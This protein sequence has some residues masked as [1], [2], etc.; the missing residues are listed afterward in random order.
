MRALSIALLLST[1][2]SAAPLRFTVVTSSGPIATL[3]VTQNGNQLDDV[4]RADDNG[5]GSK[6]D[7]HIQLGP[8]GLPVSW[9]VAGKGWYGA[10]V[11][12]HF[13]VEG[14]KAR[15]TSL[16]GSGEADAKDALY[17]AND[18]T[19]YATQIYLQVLLA[20]K[21]HR[22]AVVPGG[23]L[24]AERLHDVTI[25]SGKTKEVV[26]AWTLWGFGV[27]PSFVLVRKDR[28][29]AS[30]SPGWVFVED[31]HKGEFDALSKLAADLS[32]EVLRALTA[33]VTHRVDGP[34]WLTGVRV[35]DSATGKV[36]APT[37][38]GVFR[39]SIVYV[40]PN[41]PPPD[42]TLVDGAGGTLLPGLFDS[43]D[44]YGD[45]AGP[46]HLACGVTFGRDPG[47]D[48]D[49]I[50]RL[51]Q[52][53]HSGEFLGPR[54]KKSGFLE[55]KS[56]FSAHT[57]FIVDSVEEAKTK[58]RWYA[59]HGFWGIKIYNSMNP[60]LVKPIAEEAHRL[61]LHVSGHVPA[62]MSSERAVRDGYD[63]INHINQLMLSFIIDPLKDDTRTPFRFTALGERMAKLDL[64]S[65]PVQ[66][67]VKLMQQKKTTLDPTLATF[68]E[69]LL[70]RPG[71]ASPCDANWLD[72]MPQSVQ[73]G[74][75]T[76]SLDVK[77][78][79]YPTYDA[80][81][82]RLEETLLML[83]RAGIPLVPGTDDM[84]GFMLHSELE[85]WVKAGIPAGDALRAA[86]LGG[87]RFLGLDAQLG[88]VTPGKLADLYL[89]DGDPTVD[90]RAI[91]KGRLVLAGGAAYYPDELDA[92]IDIQPFA[93]RAPLKPPAP[94]K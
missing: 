48:N 36:G 82:K 5:R 38:V 49:S 79:Q 10:P 29:V 77:T 32:G 26:T 86:T 19:P 84:P 27:G 25:G 30:L 70:T 52:R 56:P 39:D 16:D 89:V 15:W 31:A 42:A 81:W 76:A 63:E 4:W 73:R 93:P 59:D 41:A 13:A 20:A 83:H 2:A 14:G 68:S 78:E 18:S 61:G 35:F 47:N 50:L 37:N 11:K 54:L 12:E 65:E 17:L 91:R 74:R 33:K 46:L 1:T 85:A 92:A 55:G 43:H 3:T 9:D 28:L 21:D 87:A 45:W 64:K 71:T 60:D 88:S 24:R 69:L 22:H 72:H 90:I 34:L 51:E 8:G 67:M 7:E 62:F 44:H 57:G 94:S 58:V 66:R 53:V 80:S 75:R 40:G 6:L 23:T